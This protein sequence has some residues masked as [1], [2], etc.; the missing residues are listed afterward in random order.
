M[1]SL[2]QLT[3]ASTDAFSPALIA[4][5]HVPLQAVEVPT[6]M[7]SESLAQLVASASASAIDP[8]TL[9]LMLPHVASMHSAPP[10]LS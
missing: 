10:T 3:T 5:P 7:H 6:M 8:P 2:T 1:L 9:V 4:A